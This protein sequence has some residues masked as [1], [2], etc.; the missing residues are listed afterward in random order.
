MTTRRGG[1]GLRRVTTGRPNVA[2]ASPP[3]GRAAAAALGSRRWRMSRGDEAA[4]A[5]ALA[6]STREACTVRKCFRG[7][8]KVVPSGLAQPSNCATRTSTGIAT[9]TSAVSASRGEY[10]ITGR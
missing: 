10:R 4:R 8:G 2:A 9:G 5:A 6:G 3:A 1:P 7:S